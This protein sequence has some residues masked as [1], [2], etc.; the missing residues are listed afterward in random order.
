[1][2]NRPIPGGGRSFQK[3]KKAADKGG[4]LRSIIRLQALFQL[5]RDAAE[6]CIQLGADAVDGS[7]NHNR[8][9]GG[10]QAIFDGRRS[11]L[12]LPKAGKKMRHTI[13]PYGS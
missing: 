8:D 3:T 2:S 1:M 7:D 5:R 13:A 9:A 4:L 10:D 12:I 11:G 6:A